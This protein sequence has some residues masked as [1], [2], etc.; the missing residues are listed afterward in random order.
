MGRSTGTA[1]AVCRD[2]QGNYMGS[3]SL[4]IY[5]MQDPATL[6]IIA[7]R[8]ALALAEDLAT[9]NICVASD[10]QEVVNDINRGTGGP[11]AA[12]IHEI[13]LRC[14]SFNSFSFAHERRN[15][16]YEAHNLAKFACTPGIGRHVW[17]GNPHDP[18][19]VPMN[20][21]LNQ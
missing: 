3:S 20:I 17:L 21:V 19:R 5:D 6:E 11:N 18:N 14:N 16:N 10:C 4:L 2:D 12:L 13:M 8:E 1:A 15:H 7:C 9:T